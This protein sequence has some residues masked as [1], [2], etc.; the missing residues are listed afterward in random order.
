MIRNRAIRRL[1]KDRR[2]L[3]SG[4]EFPDW[5]RPLI[6]G[7]ACARVT[8]VDMASIFGGHAVMSQGSVSM[9]G[10]PDQ[11]AA[12]I[13]DTPEL[14]FQDFHRWRE[15][16]HTEWVRYYVDHSRDEIYDWLIELGVT[17]PEVLCPMATPFP[18][19]ISPQDAVLVWSHRSIVHVWNSTT[20]SSSGMRRFSSC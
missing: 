12:D 14:A 9:I 11:A 8:V 6:W 20:F 19:N 7:V 18:G 4:Q 17:F 2:L 16:P 10:T 1:P 15:D 13:Q 3:L 5:R